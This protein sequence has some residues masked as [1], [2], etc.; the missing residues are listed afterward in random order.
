MEVPGTRMSAEDTATGIA[1]TFATTPRQSEE[2]RERVRTMVE[3]HNR[4]HGMGGGEHAAH[5]GGSGT[6][7]G[8]DTPHRMPPP[9]RAAV[10]E[11]ENGARIVV[12]PNDP[13]DL[14]ELRS[15]VRAHAEAMREGRCGTTGSAAGRSPRERVSGA[16]DRERT[17]GSPAHGDAASHE[18]RDLGPNQAYVGIG[19]GVDPNT[20]SS[21]ASA[22]VPHAGATGTGSGEPTVP[23]KAQP[24]RAPDQP[25]P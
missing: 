21:M 15:T 7:H 10:E 16:A 11:V 13:A 24:D 12:T 6:G 25:P 3:M 4:H 20:S 19:I 18:L 2:L 9:S 1:L 5:V 17:R 8:G 14:N 22:H 23:K